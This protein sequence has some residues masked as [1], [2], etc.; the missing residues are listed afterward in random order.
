MSNK[1][2]DFFPEDDFDAIKNIFDY[3]D[4]PK[5]A[6]Q[7]AKHDAQPSTIHK[8]KKKLHQILLN[9]IE[10]FAMFIVL[11]IL[12]SVVF[13]CMQSNMAKLHNETNNKINAL[14]TQIQLLQTE[15]LTLETK[16]E[17]YIT[18]ENK[19]PINIT[20]NI[21]GVDKDFVYDPDNGTLTETPSQDN[22]PNTPSDDQHQ[23]EP[24]N[25]PEDFDTRPFFGVGFSEE[26]L[27]Q[28]HTNGLPVDYVY[29]YSPAYFAGMDIGDVIISI[30]GVKVNSK[31]E[32]DAA[33]A[34]YKAKDE[35]TIEF[36]KQ[37]DDGLVINVAKQAL[38]YRGNFDLG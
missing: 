6:K 13:A 35:I 24:E 21:A 19:K 16:L 32:L 30:N 15:I 10:G 36:G 2:P 20:L 4:V 17:L 23:D 11:M 29:Q 25:F 18:D 3:R 5:Q 37:T 22:Q 1:I 28:T 7:I 38:T 31:E 26:T 12:V 14:N 33:L 27:N 34:P 8:P 9:K